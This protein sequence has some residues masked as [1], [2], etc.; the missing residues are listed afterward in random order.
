SWEDHQGPHWSLLPM[1]RHGLA[2]ISDGRGSTKEQIAATARILVDQ[3]FD[4][5]ARHQVWLRVVGD[6][7]GRGDGVNH[8]IRRQSLFLEPASSSLGE[9]YRKC[10]GQIGCLKCHMEPMVS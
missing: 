4:D 5:F 7:A 10:P 2:V 8:E 1:S 6:S 9:R 3:N